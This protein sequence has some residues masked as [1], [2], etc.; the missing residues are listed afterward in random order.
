MLLARFAFQACLIDR[1][2]ISPFRINNLRPRVGRDSRDCDK[3][4]NVPRSLTGFSSIAVPTVTEARAIFER[5]GKARVAGLS[6]AAKMRCLGGGA[7]L[8]SSAA[9]SASR[10]PSPATDRAPPRPRLLPPK[11]S[12]R[13][14]AVFAA[15]SEALP[16]TGPRLARGRGAN[17]LAALPT[18]PTRILL[19]APWVVDAARRVPRARPEAAVRNVRR[20]RTWVHFLRLWSSLSPAGRRRSS[21]RAVGNPGAGLGLYIAR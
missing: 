14:A 2:S 17:P 12:S 4:S 5:V 9:I 18:T 1:S 15:G 10:T 8:S 7:A 13:V 19:L 6:I 20:C 21:R 3:S 11:L 16:L